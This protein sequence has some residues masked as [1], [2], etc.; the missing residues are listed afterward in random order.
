MQKRAV[1]RVVES[2][3]KQ[4]SGLQTRG[5]SPSASS[6]KAFRPEAQQKKSQTA[7]DELV[8]AFKKR[9]EKERKGKDKK[10]GKKQEQKKDRESASP[11]RAR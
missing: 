11:R 8:A 4:P 1:E 2:W 9:K 10:K 5:R 6:L 7:S 3:E